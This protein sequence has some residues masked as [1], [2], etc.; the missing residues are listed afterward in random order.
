MINIITKKH[1]N[2]MFW[3]KIHNGSINMPIKARTN[4]N[5]GGVITFEL[6]I[7]SINSIKSIKSI[8]YIITYFWN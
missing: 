5:T 7:K 8:N 4:G 6:Q 3:K 2:N 1:K